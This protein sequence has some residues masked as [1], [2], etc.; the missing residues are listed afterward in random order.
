VEEA[1]ESS[2]C[3]ELII[4][5]NLLRRAQVEPLLNES[6]E[7]VKIMTQSRITAG[8]SKTRTANAIGN[9]QSKIG[10]LK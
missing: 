4:E 6:N 10:N 7:L 1:D 9:R 8:R 5:G 3:L 2:Y